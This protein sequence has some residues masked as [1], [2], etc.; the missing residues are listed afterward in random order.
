MK[1]HVIS[2]FWTDL[3]ILRWT[4]CESWLKRMVSGSNTT[5]LILYHLRTDPYS[6]PCHFRHEMVQTRISTMAPCHF[7]SFPLENCGNSLRFNSK[8][9]P[10]SIPMP[11][12]AL[13]H[14]SPIPNALP[15][16]A[17]FVGVVLCSSSSHT[18]WSSFAHFLCSSPPYTLRVY[19]VIIVFI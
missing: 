6:N 12:D 8:T 7:R 19:T 16:P 15:I 17:P 9:L 18:L 4:S 2:T 3:E 5:Y 14:F 10:A 1:K 11:P 13:Q